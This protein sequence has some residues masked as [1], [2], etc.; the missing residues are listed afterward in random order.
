MMPR[1]HADPAE[2]LLCRPCEPLVPAALSCRLRAWWLAVDHPL[3]ADPNWDIAAAAMFPGDRPGLVLV[4]AKAH[5]TELSNEAGGK[6]HQPRSSSAN[7]ER[8]GAAIGEACH[9][10]G[11]DDAGVR[12]SRDHHYQFSNRVTFAW[13]VATEGI[14]T[15]LIYLGF[16]GDEAIAG[17]DGVIQDAAHWA[18]TV[19]G[20]TANVL[21][22]H[23]WERPIATGKAELWILER[24]LPCLRQSPPIDERRSSVR[25]GAL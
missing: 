23:Y 17:A 24:S 22:S 15:V 13:K 12:L 14:P 6:R 2:A 19:S 10:L 1:G 5:L 21:P 16:T 3:A 4:E 25:T 11:G 20:H 7:H 9:A 8:I 18:R